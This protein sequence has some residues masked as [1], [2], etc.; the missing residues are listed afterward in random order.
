MRSA[1][2][3][4]AADMVLVVC[5]SLLVMLR[6]NMDWFAGLTGERKKPEINF[7]IPA[8]SFRPDTG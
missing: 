5:K 2:F 3:V 1:A 6:V 7:E 4:G 8:L